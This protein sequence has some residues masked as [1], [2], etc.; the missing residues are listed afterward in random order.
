M[1]SHELTDELTIL[2]GRAHYIRNK[3]IGDGITEINVDVRSCMDDVIA[4]I[5]RLNKVLAVDILQQDN[6]GE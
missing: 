2:Y 6:K 4:R 3:V 1:P 5:D